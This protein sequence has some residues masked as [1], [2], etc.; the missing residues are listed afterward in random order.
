MG[1]GTS[2]TRV[3]RAFT[4]GFMSTSGAIAAADAAGGRAFGERHNC[5]VRYSRAAL[6]STAQG[7]GVE[8]KQQP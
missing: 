2:D 5:S 3:V 8:R 7:S 4:A 6:F 1:G